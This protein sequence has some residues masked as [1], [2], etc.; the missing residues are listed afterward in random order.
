MGGH[1]TNFIFLYMFGIFYNK[2]GRERE[3][4]R[5]R[6][7]AWHG[8]NHLISVQQVLVSLL[9]FFEVSIDVMT[10]PLIDTSWRKKLSESLMFFL[11][12]VL[13]PKDT[14]LPIVW[15]Q[16]HESYPSLWLCTGGAV[17]LQSV[18]RFISRE[19]TWEM[20]HTYEGSAGAPAS[21]LT[22]GQ[23]GPVL[24]SAFLFSKDWAQAGKQDPWG[25]FCTWV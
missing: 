7:T 21:E 20:R 17:S 6:T 1:Y 19:S 2:K 11:N 18:C 9:A 22:E 25:I 16:G 13:F 5:E 15:S 3:W 23:K 8:S 14:V 4:E 24:R 10:V 12:W